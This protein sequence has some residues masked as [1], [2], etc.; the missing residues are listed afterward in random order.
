MQSVDLIGLDKLDKS[1]NKLLKEFPEKRREL[2]EEFA[3]V[4]KETLNKQIDLSLTDNSGKIKSWQGKYVG[5]KGGYAAVR[6]V[7]TSIGSS[8]PGAITNYLNSGHKIRRPSGKNKNYKPRINKIY[9]DGR[10]FY[11]KT[12][13]QSEAELI[14]IAEKFADSIVDELNK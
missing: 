12:L 3:D 13:K 7:D 1:I 8:S 6:A 10:H 14:A 5:S 9:V 2:H 11:Q 4:L